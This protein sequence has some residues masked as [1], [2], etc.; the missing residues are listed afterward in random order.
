MLS[1]DSV[2]CRLRLCIQVSPCAV[3][4]TKDLIDE[5]FHQVKAAEL[6]TLAEAVRSEN[7]RIYALEAQRRC[8]LHYQLTQALTSMQRSATFGRY[9]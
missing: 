2:I 9:Q 6:E 5:E 8:V 1:K 4:I 7:H 3:L